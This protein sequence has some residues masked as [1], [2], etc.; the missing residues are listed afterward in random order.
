[1]EHLRLRQSLGLGPK[2]PYTPHGKLARGPNWHT[3]KL[4]VPEPLVA[5][6]QLFRGA[7]ID[8]KYPLIHDD[9][10]L[11]VY[12]H[13]TGNMIPG[14]LR[15]KF[16]R[17][18]VLDWSPPPQ[19]AYRLNQADAAY[20]GDHDDDDDENEDGEY[21]DD[22][23]DHGGGGNIEG[24]EGM[25]SS[26]NKG[27]DVTGGGVVTTSDMLMQTISDDE[28]L[29]EL[30]FTP[31]KALWFERAAMLAATELDD[32]PASELPLLILHSR[33]DTAHTK[34]RGITNDQELYKSLRQGLKGFVKVKLVYGKGA[35]VMDAA[36]QIALWSKADFIVAPHGGALSWMVSNRPG[37][38]VLLIAHADGVNASV[39]AAESY[40]T[41]MGVALGHDVTTL[42][43]PEGGES[44]FFSNYSFMD[45]EHGYG[46]SVIDAVTE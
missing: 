16:K 22:E 31:V 46:Q 10:R 36:Q 2:D 41:Y 42:T 45:A 25:Q 29:P 26:Q 1:M 32:E 44:S 17:L 43:L 37:T 11:I 23:Y 5:Y 4:L 24:L 6:V 30:F 8:V 35:L 9:K 13:S 33:R 40:F 21:G 28:W 12:P 34:G 19:V 18:F 20:L 38:K 15:L 7:F 39:A 27:H 14:S 3:A